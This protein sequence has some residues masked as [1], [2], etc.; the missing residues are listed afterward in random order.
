MDTAQRYRGCLLGLAAGDA[1]GTALEFRQPGSFKPIADMIGGGP[2]H[3]APGQWTDDTSMALCLAESLLERQGFDGTDQL[4][5]YVRWWR[6]GHFSS[7]GECFDIGY[8]TREALGRFVSTRNPFCGSTD[9]NKAGN[10]SIM[11]LAPIPMYFL[12]DPEQAIEMAADSSR[13]THGAFA[14]VDA[15]RYL[16]ALII[17]ALR[18]V[19]RQILLSE[20]YCPVAGYWEAHPLIP[21][22]GEIA[23]GSFKRKEP[24]DIQGSGYAVR[25][26]E[27]ALWAFH[28][29]DNFPDGCLLAANLGNDADTTAAVYGQLAGAFYGEPGIPRQWLDKLAMRDKIAEIADR[30]CAESQRLVVSPVPTVNGSEPVQNSGQKTDAAAHDHFLEVEVQRAADENVMPAPFDRSY[31]VVPGKFLAGAYPGD[32]VPRSA[33]KKLKAILGAGIRCFVDLTSEEDRNLFSQFLVPYQDLVTKIAGMHF[34]TTYRRMPITDLQVPSRAEM[35]EIL[36]LIDGAILSDL[37]VYVHCLGGIGRTGTVVGCWLARHGIAQGVPAIDL[38]RKLRRHDAHA[39]IPSPETGRQR[40]FICD[41]KK[42]D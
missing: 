11:R 29:S 28:K 3:L 17:G 14:A 10:G 35:E 12:D 24:P 32:P 41:W 37:P 38:I 5:R 8:T 19:S 20:L 34:R 21:E 40:Q 9:S 36:D 42:G 39:A 26:L 6:D 4:E 7:T 16:A 31:W 30:L 25:S 33:E 22:I 15:C 27:A 23:S 1:V 13:T 2:F 18:G